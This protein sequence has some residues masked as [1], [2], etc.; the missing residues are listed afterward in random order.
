M[1]KCL[2][3]IKLGFTWYYEKGIKKCGVHKDIS[4]NVSYISGNVSSIRGNVSSIS[5]DVSYISGN[6]S[7]ISGNVDESELTEKEKKN[8]VNVEDLIKDWL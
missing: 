8:R 1:K 6:V 4:G 2:L 3:R 5:G 7:Y